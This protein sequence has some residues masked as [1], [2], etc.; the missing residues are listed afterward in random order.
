MLRR[1]GYGAYFR[2]AITGS[3]ISFV[4]Y[5]FLDDTDLCITSQTPNDTEADV[6]LRMQQALDL[7]EGGIRATGGANVP[8][9]SHWYLIDLKWQQGNWRDVTEIEAPAHLIVRDCD[10][11]VAM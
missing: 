10:G 2:T 9:K 6:A 4:G 7:W 8:E 11:N 5:A 1:E 3:T